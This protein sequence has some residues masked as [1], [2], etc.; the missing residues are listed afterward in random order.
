MEDKTTILSAFELVSSFVISSPVNPGNDASTQL[1]SN[2]ENALQYLETL[3]TRRS[4]TPYP[5]YVIRNAIRNAIRIAADSFNGATNTSAVQSSVNVPT[6]RLSDIASNDEGL[7]ALVP[8]TDFDNLE[9][10][11][12]SLSANL[13]TPTSAFFDYEGYAADSLT[14]TTADYIPMPEDADPPL[15]QFSTTGQVTYS[16]AGQSVVWDHTGREDQE[17]CRDNHTMDG[18]ANEASRHQVQVKDCRRYHGDGA[19]LG[20]PLSTSRETV[21]CESSQDLA[22]RGSDQTGPQTHD[23]SGPSP[24]TT[25][26]ATET[27]HTNSTF[28][29]TM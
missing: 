28:Y 13:R 16:A 4:T 17:E 6:V 12:T 8:N 10:G 18:G 23:A 15:G 19:G 3:L 27:G 14:Q 22:M 9:F 21:D 5:D 26:H 2:V 29:R 1:R 24:T 20:Q 7:P 11:T 25:A